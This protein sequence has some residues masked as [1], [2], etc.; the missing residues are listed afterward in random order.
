MLVKHAAPLGDLSLE[1]AAR[2]T[3]ERG[4]ADALIVSGTGTGDTTKLDDVRR[5]RAA[6]PDA[7]I[8]VGSGVTADNVGEYLEFADGV[9]V[10]SSLKRGGKLTQA[11]DPRRVAALRAAM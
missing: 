4:L 1:I 2:D 3:L 9:I 6:C 7:A 10:G 5:V 11:V 8:L